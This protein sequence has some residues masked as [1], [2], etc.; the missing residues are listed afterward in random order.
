MADKFT[1]PG[2]YEVNIVRKQDILDCIED[3]IFDKEVAVEIIN[4]LSIDIQ[5]IVEEGGWAGVPFVGS[6]Y[7]KQ[8]TVIEQ[9]EENQAILNAAKEQMQGAEFVAFRRQLRANNAKHIAEEKLY[10]YNLSHVVKKNSKAF[11]HLCKRKSSLAARLIT[12]GTLHLEVVGDGYE[13]SEY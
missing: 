10:R 12:F 5:R 11:K 1:F 9:G 13:K 8:G 4:Q 2:G 3:S 7:V 6:F